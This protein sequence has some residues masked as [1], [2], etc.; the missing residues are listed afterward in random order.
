MGKLV[1]EINSDLSLNFLED[2]DNMLLQDSINYDAA[3]IETYKS[4][5]IKESRNSSSSECS[6]S[7]TLDADPKVKEPSTQPTNTKKSK[8]V[9][10]CGCTRVLDQ[11][12]DTEG[13]LVFAACDTIGSGDSNME[14]TYQ[15]EDGQLKSSNRLIKVN[16]NPI[17]S[18][19]V[20][21]GNH[22]N[23]IHIE[24]EQL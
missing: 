23:V 7:C 20:F 15:Y 5:E 6:R 8:P 19:T 14:V 3:I 11:Q 1:S 2:I 17:E 21:Y 12:F 13:N 10:S 16:G 4:N 22:N 9:V 24:R 18:V